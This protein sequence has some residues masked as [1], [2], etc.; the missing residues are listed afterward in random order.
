[1]SIKDIAG[2]MEQIALYTERYLDEPWE[3][4]YLLGSFFDESEKGYIDEADY[5]RKMDAFINDNIGVF[6]Y[7]PMLPKESFF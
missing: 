7:P 2:L 4:M 1:M 3:T 5:R 6:D